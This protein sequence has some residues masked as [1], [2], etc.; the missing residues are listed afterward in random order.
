MEPPRRTIGQRISQAAQAFE[1]RQTKHGRKWVA[2][3]MNED[4]IVIALHG[5]LTAQEKALAQSPAGA[6]QV[7]EFHRQLFANASGP[8]F[9]EIKSITGMEVRDT[10]VEIEKKTGSVVQIFTTNT[11]AEEFLFAS[12]GSAGTWE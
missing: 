10:T 11:V 4:T 1:R 3:F 9:Q 2:V 12:S 5:S 6:A 8:L 7:L